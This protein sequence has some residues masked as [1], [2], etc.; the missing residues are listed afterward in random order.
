MEPNE[1]GSI[2]LPGASLAPA[3]LLLVSLLCYQVVSPPQ[4]PS[5]C[6]SAHFLAPFSPAPTCDAL[7]WCDVYALEAA[8]AGWQCLVWA[9]SERCVRAACLAP[10]V[11]GTDPGLLWAKVG[12]HARQPRLHAVDLATSS[13]R[14]DEG[15]CAHA[16]APGRRRALQLPCQVMHHSHLHCEQT[17][18]PHPAALNLRRL[19]VW[20]RLP[21]P[22]GS[23]PA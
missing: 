9:G 22:G 3:Y 19:T 10:K 13:L 4:A 12:R 16:A 20:R 8:K 18:S 1:A 6:V 2:F 15:R 23:H 21:L 14:Y 11:Q 17:W 7:L 5:L